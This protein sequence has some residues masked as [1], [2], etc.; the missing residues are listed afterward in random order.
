MDLHQPTYKLMV[1]LILTDLYQSQVLKSCALKIMSR[2]AMNCAVVLIGAIDWRRDFVP[3]L[4][5]ITPHHPQKK[6]LDDVLEKIEPRS[7]STS[8]RCT[9]YHLGRGVW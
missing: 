3:P 9:M 6:W 5:R 8:G 4:S 7:D 2:T 1:N